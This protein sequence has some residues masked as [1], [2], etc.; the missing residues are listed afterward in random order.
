MFKESDLSK[1][2]IRKLTALRK[3]IGDKLGTEAFAKWLKEEQSKVAVEK[4]DPV[5]DKIVEALKSFEN[6]T[7][8]KLG[9][10]GYVI[11]RARGKGAKG[12]IAEKVTK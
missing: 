8:F 9:N 5:A 4:S 2:Q 10:K 12:F 6:D 1:G 11:K 3:S 7:S